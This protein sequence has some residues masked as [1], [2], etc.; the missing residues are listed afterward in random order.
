MLLLEELQHVSLG[1]LSDAGLDEDQLLSLGQGEA[2]AQRAVGRPVALYSHSKFAA[3][4]GSFVALRSRLQQL[5]RALLVKL[6]LGVAERLGY[7][8]A[9]SKQARA[10]EACVNFRRH[11]N[12]QAAA[13]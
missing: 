3:S 13:S 2:V 7:Q 10:E 11:S 5:A 9:A 1:R 4:S 6:G 12:F 8:F